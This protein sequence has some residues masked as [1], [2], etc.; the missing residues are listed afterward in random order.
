MV[1]HTIPTRIAAA[2][3]DSNKSQP[4]I[5]VPHSARRALALACALVLAAC[6]APQVKPPSPPAPAATGRA[7]YEAVAFAALPGWSSDAVDAAWPAFLVGCRAL[8]AAPSTREAWNAPCADAAAMSAPDTPAARAF[9]ESHFTAYRIA[10]ASG[11]DT[12]LFTGYYEPLLTGARTASGSFGVPLYAVPDDLLV[13]DLASLYP[14]LKGKRVRGRLEGRRVVPYFARADIDAGRAPLADKVLAWVADPVEAFFLEIQGSGRI[15]LP[16]GG[17]MRVGYADQ[18]G[19][20]FHSIARVL[21]DRGELTADTASMQAIKA[22]GRAH[23]AALP[24]L[25]EENPSYVFF[26]E[27]PA[28][29][30]GSLDA[31]IDGPIGSLGVPLLAQR[32]IAVDTRYVPLGAPVFVDT[33][34]P[35]TGSALQRLTLAQDTGGAIRGIARADFFW[36]FG[37]GAGREAG[38]M[39]QQ[40]RMWILWPRGATLPAGAP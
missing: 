7:A 1:H 29:P 4:M 8:L 35:L 34:N 23:P 25:L 15:A 33:Q 40:G 6:Q 10:D 28:P 39:R 17:V 26:R 38:R 37:D 13:V 9:F 19:H 12:G 22:W 2:T 20:P 18:N 32:T 3:N 16:D 27:I 11:R 24:A 14:E 36:G 21:I 31:R 30:A 5:D